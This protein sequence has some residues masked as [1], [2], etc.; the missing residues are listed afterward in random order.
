MWGLYMKKILI[1]TLIILLVALIGAGAYVYNLLDMMETQLVDSETEEV[2]PETPEEKKESLGISKEAPTKE[3][4]GVTN[5]LLFGLDNRKDSEPGHSDAIMI[6]SI[7][8]K[9]KS[10]KLTSLMRD[11][12]VDIPGKKDNRINTAY[13]MGGPALAIKTVNTNFDMNIEDYV[14]VDFH[15]L[16]QIINLVDGIE[17]ELSKAEAKAINEYIDELNKISKDGTKVKR[18]TKSGL[19]T[20]NGRQAT[21]YARIRSVGRDDFERTERQRRVMS[22]LF[23]KAK[24]ISVTKIPELV[25]TVLPNVKTS[26]DKGEI[27]DLAIA[28]LGFGTK[29]IEQFRIPTDGSFSDKKIDGMLVLAPDIEKNTEALHNFIY[30]TNSDELD[31]D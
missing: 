27:V 19:Q 17:I 28:V 11:M 16:E 31:E 15:A 18:I 12:Y 4:T 6:A 2:I 24:N 25:T 29:D 1:T 14:T 3:D 30:G 7:D 5:I 22:E 8:R 20:L 10:I 13:F 23:K 9:N 21:A 26:L